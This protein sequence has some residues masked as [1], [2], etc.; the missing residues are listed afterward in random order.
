LFIDSWRFSK[1]LEDIFSKAL[2]VLALFLL[3]GHAH[4]R[5]GQLSSLGCSSSAL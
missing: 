2:S 1:I 5:R 3:R 4:S